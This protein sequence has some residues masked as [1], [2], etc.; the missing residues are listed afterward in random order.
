MADP[1]KTR[2]QSDLNV[3]RKSRDKGRTLVLST[4]L[5]ELNNLE[6]ETGRDATDTDAVQVF[7]RAIKR[8]RE[9][10]DQM[11]A[12]R[13]ELAEKE[14]AEAEVLKAYLP[15]GLSEAEVR[16]LIRE[17]IAGGAAQM[18]EVM[19]QVMPKLKG[20]FDGKEANRLVRE[21]LAR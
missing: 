21:E 9:A 20:R 4:T 2:L 11:R 17:A 13:P 7:T 8:R 10:A 3:A 5:S 18:P 1:L 16:A 15:E 14:E 19:G 12:T 6:I